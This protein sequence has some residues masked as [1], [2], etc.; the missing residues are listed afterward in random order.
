MAE[1]GLNQNWN[2]DYDPVV[3]RY[4]ESDLIGLR[5][6]VNT[7][8]YA[9]NDVLGRT[10]PSGLLVQGT[11]WTGQGAYWGR[12]KQA[13]AKIRSVVS[14]S[15]S[16]NSDGSSGSCIPCN[17]VHDLAD[18]LDRSVVHYEQVIPLNPGQPPGTVNCGSALLVSPR[19]TLGEAAFTLPP[20][21]C[22]ASTLYH[23][24]L[25]NIGWDEPKTRAAEA[26]CVGDLCGGQSD[27]VDAIIIN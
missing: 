9:H 10:D 24:L 26:R 6:G 5:G 12:V 22:L 25:H 15:C 21:G 17:L 19:I 27:V 18:Y 14:K 2:R 20:C 8:A 1:T 16:C 13:E 4:V 3:A 23:E 7:Y 11:G